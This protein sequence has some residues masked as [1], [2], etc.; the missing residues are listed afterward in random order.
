MP[1]NFI[2]NTSTPP[3]Q[4][5]ALCLSSH[6]S[7]AVEQM[8]P[9]VTKK[10]KT[11]KLCTLPITCGSDLRTANI[12]Q[13]LAKTAPALRQLTAQQARFY[14]RKPSSALGTAY[15]FVLKRNSTYLLFVVAGAIVTEAVYGTVGDAVW[16]TVNSGVSRLGLVQPALSTKFCCRKH[17]RRWTGASLRPSQLMRMTRTT[18]MMRM[19]MSN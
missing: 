14:S 17:T 19:M 9:C 15:H 16:A 7:A 6:A 1:P 13:C 18:R 12:M 11:S 10:H 2:A 4:Q 8:A 5:G 3:V